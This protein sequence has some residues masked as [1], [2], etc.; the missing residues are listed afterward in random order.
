MDDDEGKLSMELQ[1][2]SNM[3]TVAW[4]A[5]EMLAKESGA[6]Y[7][8]QVDVYSFGMVLWELYEC[9]QPFS[10]MLS[11]FDIMDAVRKGVRP[12]ISP[13][14]PELYKDLIIKCVSQDPKL[15]PTFS[16]IVNRLE[17]ELE[18][19]NEAKSDNDS[20]THNI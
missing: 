9:K 20:S 3:G 4:A 1:M 14:C 5:P 8:L 17:R 19:L 15:R 2:T 7:G 11:R 16:F 12:P 6:N 18:R 10:E 13:S